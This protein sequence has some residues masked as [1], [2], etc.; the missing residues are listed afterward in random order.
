MDTPGVQ[1]ARMIVANDDDL[2]GLRAAGAVVRDALKAMRDAVAPGVTTA[3][4][5]DVAARVFAAAGARSAP[6]L[7]YEFPGETC[8]S[9]NHEI[10]HGIPSRERVLESGDLLKLDVTAELAGYMAD[11]AVT[12]G[13]G[14][15]GALA[16]KLA[17]CAEQAF[18]KA[19]RVVRPGTRVLEIGR[20]VE[21]EVNRQGFAVV[22]LLQGHGIGRDLHEDPMVPNWPDPEAREFL[23]D[24]MV[25][26]IEPIIAAGRGDLVEGEDGW[27]LMTVDGSLA[28]HFEHTLMVRKGAPLLLTE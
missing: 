5:D 24:G 18:R 10:V 14:E 21:A 22:R 28:A 23:E 19:L 3:D 12:V 7:V 25:L 4:L 15:T 1:A 9:V 26:T 8:I 2:R 11:A 13:V 6:R 17:A 27:T 20:V 16:R